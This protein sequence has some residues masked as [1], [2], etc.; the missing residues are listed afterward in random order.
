MTLHGLDP[1]SNKDAAAFG[2]AC[3]AGSPRHR[4]ATVTSDHLK[5][6]HDRGRYALG[7]VHKLNGVD[8]A[9]YIIKNRREFGIGMTGRSGCTWPR[10]D[11]ERGAG[12]PYALQVSCTFTATLP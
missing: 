1:L 5:K 11:P 7:A 12:T 4:P 10:T 6:D 2:A 3:P 9:A 8:G